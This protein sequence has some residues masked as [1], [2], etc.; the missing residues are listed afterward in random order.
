[1]TE[2][3]EDTGES[4]FTLA[5]VLVAFAILALV[6][7]AMMRAF[8]GTSLALSGAA[9]HEARLDLAARLVE[10]E[11]ARAPAEPGRREGSEGALG[12]WTS[13]E[14]VEGAGLPAPDGTPRLFRVVVG[15]GP[16][17]GAPAAPL[18]RTL[19]LARGGDGS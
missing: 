9:T 3:C 6:T 7:L 15:V 18:L 16:K 5:E 11:R 10:T 1:M 13:V 4:G 2:N 17:D 8:S 19:I 14:P 12:W